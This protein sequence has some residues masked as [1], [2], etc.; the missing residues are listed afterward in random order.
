M[1]IKIL[2]LNTHARTHAC[3]HTHI[4]HESPVDIQNSQTSLCCRKQAEGDLECVTHHVGEES[5]GMF[6]KADD[7]LPQVM[8]LQPVWEG[9]QL[10]L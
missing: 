8:P 9:S 5:S 10:A 3:T 6:V 4:Y 2:I 7:S 1:R